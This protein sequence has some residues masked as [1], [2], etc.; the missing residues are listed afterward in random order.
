MQ[1]RRLDNHARA[2]IDLANEIA[3]EFELEYVGTEHVLLA[4]LRHGDNV[5]ARALCRLGVDEDKARAQIDALYQRAKEDTWVTGRLPGSPHFRNV[6]ERAMDVAEQLESNHIGSEHLLL[7][8]YHEQ[9]NTGLNAL[10][11]LGITHKKC[12]DAVL[13]ELN[14]E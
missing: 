7:A 4:V 2:I 1:L 14:H 9:E 11:S 13:A 3:R 12:R 5:G 10:S 6:I 8:L